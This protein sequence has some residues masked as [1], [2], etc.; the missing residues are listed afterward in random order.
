MYGA[1][2]AT[3]RSRLVGARTVKPWLCS[4]VATAFQLEAS[5]HA[6]WT[7]TIVGFDIVRTLL[8]GQSRLQATSFCCWRSGVIS[9]TFQ[10]S[11]V[12]RIAR[13]TQ[14]VGSRRRSHARRPWNA[15]RGN[16]WWLWCQD[17]PIESRES[18][19]TLVE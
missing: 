15:E 3:D 7:R 13:I 16:V 2:I 18:Q 1:S 8:S 12:R 11:F 14:P 17:S 5:A 4:S 19:A 10:A 6:P 9:T